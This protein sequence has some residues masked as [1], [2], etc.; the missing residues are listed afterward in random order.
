MRPGMKRFIVSDYNR[1][2]RLEKD[3]VG[4]IEHNLN[5]L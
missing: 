5:A 3:A 4:V 2:R 1:K